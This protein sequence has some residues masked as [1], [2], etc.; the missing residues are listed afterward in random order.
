MVFVILRRQCCICDGISVS[1]HASPCVIFTPDSF[2]LFK[3]ILV[4][5]LNSF[6]GTGQYVLQITPLCARS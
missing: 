3:H 5:A 6:I 1:R 2:E 4:I